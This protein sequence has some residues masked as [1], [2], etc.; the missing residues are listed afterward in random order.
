MRIRK[1]A[2]LKAKSIK[3]SGCTARHLCVYRASRT[4]ALILVTVAVIGGGLS[5]STEP[6]AANNVTPH[7]HDRQDTVPSFTE[8]RGTKVGDFWLVGGKFTASYYFG[9]VHGT[10]KFS[11]H[12]PDWANLSGRII[13]SV[14]EKRTGR[15]TYHHVRSF[16]PVSQKG[17]KGWK[18]YSTR[19]ELDGRVKIVARANTDASGLYGNVGLSSVKLKFVD[20]LPEWKPVA[21]ELCR[22]GVH[23]GL[24]WAFWVPTSVVA[25][26]LIVYLA[27]KVS[28]RVATL[29]GPAVKLRAAEAL[30]K[31]TPRSDA[32]NLMED[33]IEDWVL[34]EVEDYST[35]LLGRIWRNAVQSY[36]YGCRDFSAS[37]MYRPFTQGYGVY[38]DDIARD[39]NDAQRRS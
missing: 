32:Q 27:P 4:M 8:G 39:L 36:E 12:I 30:A 26:V 17:R 15:N 24:L 5:V 9:D 38:A 2:A 35:G 22:Y 20:L 34:E 37:L 3:R 13:W 11:R 6:A 18:T 29:S 21:Q 10:F 14:Y 7:A 16:F 25:A 1:T 19:L 33:E 28:A 23:K 31:K